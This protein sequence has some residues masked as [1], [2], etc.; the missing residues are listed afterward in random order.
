MIV[1]TMKLTLY[2][3]WVQSLKEKRMVTKSV[4][5]KVSSKFNVAIAEVDELDTHKTIVIG[6]ACVTNSMSHCDS[7]LDNVLEFI[8]NVTEAEVIKVE[9]DI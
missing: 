1:G 8:E 5:G 2:A 6:V 7:M 9:K 3:P 4:C